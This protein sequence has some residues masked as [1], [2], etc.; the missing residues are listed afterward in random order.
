MRLLQLLITVILMILPFSNEAQISYDWGIAGGGA[1]TPENAINETVID[2]QGYRY[3]VGSFNGTVELNPSGPSYTVTS[4]GGNAD[5]LLMKY[6][7]NGQVIW[8]Q[9]IGGAYDQ[10]GY[11]LAFSASGEELVIA[12]SFDGTAD[13]DPSPAA[14]DTFFLTNVGANDFFIAKYDTSGNFMWADQFACGTQGYEWISD[15]AVDDN[16]RIYG[17]G[18]FDATVDF[19]PHPVNTN[20]ISSTSFGIADLFLVRLTSAGDLD[21]VKTIGNTT[22]QIPGEMLMDGANHLFISGK[23]SASTLDMDPGPGVANVTNATVDGFIAKYTLDG[24]YLDAMLF[25]GP[26]NWETVVDL[27]Y[28]ATKDKI[29]VTGEYIDSVNLNPQGVPYYVYGMGNVGT[30][31]IFFGI[32][33]T[34][35][36]LLH[37]F[38]VGGQYGDDAYGCLFADADDHFMI[39]GKLNQNNPDLDP[40][41]YVEGIPQNQSTSAFIAKYD[42]LGNYIYGYQY[43]GLGTKFIND[44]DVL[45]DTVLIG[46]KYYTEIDL[47]FNA[48][49]DYHDSPGTGY[50]LFNAQYVECPGNYIFDELHICAGDSAQIFGNYEST[51]G[52]FY[53]SYTNQAGCDSIYRTILVV[54]DMA[55][56]LGPDISLCDGETTVISAMTGFTS[57]TWS[58]AGTGTDYTFVA[59]QGTGTF[60]IDLIAESAAG[61]TYK[62]TVI[63]TVNGLPTVDLGADLQ[64][65]ENEEVTFDAGTGM[66]SYLWSDASTGSTLTYGSMDGSGM[67][68][69]SVIV[70]DN[71][72]CTGKDTVQLEVLPLPVVQLIGDTTICED[73]SITL[74]GPNGMAAYLWPDNTTNQTFELVGAIGTGVHVI[75]LQVTATN[76]C[77][78][79]DTVNITVE[80]CASLD[81][82]GETLTLIYPNPT[83]GNVTIDF[84]TL[85][86]EAIRVIATNGQLIAVHSIAPMK[87]KVDLQIIGERG[88]YFIELLIAD[89]DVVRHKVVLE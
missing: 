15:L 73:E 75:D 76:G 16:D 40:S 24:D 28:N 5:I 9:A 38:A 61:C 79:A 62:D 35:F 43:E 44:V 60:E 27:E 72:G 85:N 26:S 53:D 50:S 87:Q 41:P 30:E 6:H 56:D 88:M 70:T 21:Y 31:D 46:G 51:T 36:E 49:V 77:S 2:A 47:D 20:Y 12:G 68:E 22:S 58:D 84:G 81:E 52:V 14:A 48:G 25:E 64:S 80:N 11:E 4:T 23:L 7:P 83:T 33:D 65:C 59:D 86:V 37:G 66:S 1:T 39:Y 45:S 71:N 8:A 55:L 19:D 32:Y 18:R 74:T 54:D 29:L 69:F 34:S 82:L 57:Y 89:G 42:S 78:N 13:F 17:Y 63:V 10:Y 67:Y 3:S